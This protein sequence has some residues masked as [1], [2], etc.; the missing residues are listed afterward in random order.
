MRIMGIS[1][2]PEE[3][4]AASPL[5]V[6]Y[7]FREFPDQASI[8]A[9]KEGVALANALKVKDSPTIEQRRVVT[10]TI[11]KYRKTPV[12]EGT[13]MRLGMNDAIS[14]KFNTTN[15]V[16]AL[17]GDADRSAWL[18]VQTRVYPV[19]D[20]SEFLRMKADLDKTLQFE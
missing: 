7:W 10:E 1:G 15:Y 17:V 13:T 4:N 5:D 2:T 18:N 11:A 6:D 12:S 8:D 19:S 16:E 3:L 14:F 20:F 9:Y